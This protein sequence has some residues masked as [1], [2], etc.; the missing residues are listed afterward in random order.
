MRRMWQEG[1]LEEVG[2]LDPAAIARVREE[3]WP[4]VRD[5]DELH[6]VLHTLIA[7]PE[8][9]LNW[10]AKGGCPHVSGSPLEWQGYF[11]RLLEQG[12]ATRARHAGTRYWVASA[13]TQASFV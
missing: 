6:D 12:R 11:E 3:A 4:D 7:L 13:R 5:A 2:K 10:T 8:D 1:V 9:M